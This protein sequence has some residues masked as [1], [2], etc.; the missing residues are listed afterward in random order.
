MGGAVSLQSDVKPSKRI[1]PHCV[2]RFT[3]EVVQRRRAL[4]SHQG[5]PGGTPP[6]RRKDFVDIILLAEVGRRRRKCMCRG[7]G[8]GGATRGTVEVVL[9][10]DEDGRGLTDEEIQSEADTFMF[11]GWACFGKFNPQVCSGLVSRPPPPSP[12]PLPSAGHDTTASAICWTLY[13]LA[14]HAHFQDRCR[15][16][17]VDLMRGRDGE[18]MIQWS[19]KP[20]LN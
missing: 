8:G 13:N 18:E 16:E 15:Q 1:R 20:G 11:A 3:R 14:R 6:Q 4:I 5:G 12:L 7:V 2:F 17:V 9:L 10:Q 19:V